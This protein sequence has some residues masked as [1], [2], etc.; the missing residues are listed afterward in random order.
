MDD[1]GICSSV[2]CTWYIATLLTQIMRALHLVLHFEGDENERYGFSSPVLTDMVIRDNDEGSYTMTKS[3]F[4]ENR[5]EIKS[6]RMSMAREDG[7]QGEREEV[8]LA[9]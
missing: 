8:E 5:R 7:T 1:V 9:I 2:A 4:P 3:R 6:Q